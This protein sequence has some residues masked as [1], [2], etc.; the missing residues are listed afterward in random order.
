MRLGKQE[1]ALRRQAATP[2]PFDRKR[3][4][5]RLIARW[6]NKC[7]I[8]GM[9]GGKSA[10]LLHLDHIVPVSRGGDGSA[11]NLQ[12]LCPS[13]NSSKGAM[14]MGE[15]LTG[16]SAPG[17]DREWRDPKFR[18]ILRLARSHPELFR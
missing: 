7:Q 17:V 18:R 13:C 6:G 3:I 10:E 8:C 11:E 2:K 4:V 14:T 15:Y 9:H 16:E 12:L 1:A 5:G